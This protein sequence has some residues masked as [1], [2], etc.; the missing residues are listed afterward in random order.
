MKILSIHISTP[1]NNAEWWRISNIANILEDGGHEVDLV[2]YCGKS[3]YENFQ[4]K[5]KFPNDKFIITSQFDVYYK[6]L[7][8]LRDNKYDLVYA[9]TGAAAF[10]SL[11][12]RL[13]KKPLVFDMHGDLLQELLLRCG[14]SLNPKFIANYL[15]FKIMDYAN[16][17]GS[18]HIICVS[19]RMIN[20]LH[21]IKSVALNDMNY[22]TNGVDLD[23]FKPKNDIVQDLKENLGLD[24]KLIFGYVG[25]FQSWQGTENLV[26]AAESVNDSEIAFLIVGGKP[27]ISNSDNNNLIFIPKINRGEVPIYYSACDVLV[28][29]RPFHI[30]T[31][32]AAPTKFAEYTSMGKP[33]LTSNVGDAADLVRKYNSGSVVENNNVETLIN[34][35]NQFKNLDGAKLRRMGKNS[36]KLA[37]NE[38]D[39]NLV[40]K[41]L[42]KS[43]EKF[44]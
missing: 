25:G 23:F 39:W 1:E 28:L 22:V 19:N 35:F 33:V 5:D 14:Y 17:K 15:Q 18:N 43:L 29:P 4:E 30:A 31:E 12:G 27:K 37:E 44:Q 26:K 13:T 2:H 9:N 6:H 38:F 16:I 20:Y 34:G 7:K 3:K 10:C 24:D 32:V 42:L 36:R 41:N 40:G 21:T 11:S 8:L